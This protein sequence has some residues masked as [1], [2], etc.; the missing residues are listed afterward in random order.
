MSEGLGRMWLRSTDDLQN[1]LALLLLVRVAFAM[2]VVRHSDYCTSRKGLARKPLKL[3]H[4][5]LIAHKDECSGR[6]ALEYG[7]SVKCPAIAEH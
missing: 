5:T 7:R 6:V 4:Y 3:S 2:C 1:S